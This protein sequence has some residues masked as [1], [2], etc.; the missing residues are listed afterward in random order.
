M[1]QAKQK[2]MKPFEEGV[3]L[4][5]LKHFEEALENFNRCL[6]DCPKDRIAQIYIER[7]EHYLKVGW[8]QNWDGITRYD[9][10]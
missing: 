10:K 5:Y 6:I 8:D 9:T 4:Y 2:T 1:I 3:A 7:C